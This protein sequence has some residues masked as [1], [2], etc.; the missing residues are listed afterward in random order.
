MDKIT[1]NSYIKNFTLLLLFLLSTIAIQG[2]E[3]C[4]NNIDDDGD[5]LI[6]GCDSEC[7][8]LIF[9]ES[10]ENATNAG[11]IGPNCLGFEIG[12]HETWLIGTVAPFA[13]DNTQGISGNWSTSGRIWYTNN[14]NPCS[15]SGGVPTAVNFPDGNVALY[16][17]ETPAGS[18]VEFTFPS[19][20]FNVSNKYFFSIDVWNDAELGDTG[21]QVDITSTV[22]GLLQST[23]LQ[24]DAVT[25]SDGNF[26][27]LQTEIC[28]DAGAI[29]IRLTELTVMGA[30]ASPVIDNLRIT[31]SSCVFDPGSNGT[32]CFETTDTPADL[33]NFLAGSPDTGGSWSPTLAS[34]TGVFDPSV[35]TAGTY[36]YSGSLCGGGTADV[37]VTIG[38]CL[39]PPIDSD[40]DTISDFI[41]LDDDN[42]GILDKIE[43]DCFSNP[44]TAQLARWDPNIGLTN[45]SNNGNTGA[46]K[47]DRYQPSF[48]NDTYL[49]LTVSNL[50]F[51]TGVTD[52]SLDTSILTGNDVA[53]HG[54]VWVSGIDGA[55]VADA[56]TNNDYIDFSFKIK[57][58]VDI[59]ARFDNI[60]DVTT[61]ITGIWG[62]RGTNISTD[63]RKPIY[64]D[65]SYQVEISSDGFAT[66]SQILSAAHPTTR[67]TSG[68]TFTTSQGD[69]QFN[70]FDNFQ[71]GAGPSNDVLLQA[72]TTYT[73][74]IYLFAAEDVGNNVTLDNFNISINPCTEYDTDND[75]IANIYDLDSDNDGCADLEEAAG[76]FTV[77]DNGVTATG[78]LTD[79]NGGVVT[80]NLGNTV[81]ATLA[82]V[83][84]AAGGGQG[85]G[86][87]QDGINYCEDFDDD[88]V[89]DEVDLDDDN[90]GILDEFDVC[91]I[92]TTTTDP[93]GAA[94]N[95]EAAGF[96]I[97]SVGG[98]TDI[99]GALDNGFEQAVIR[100]G[101]N[102]STLS[103]ASDYITT[104][105][106]GGGTADTSVIQFSNGTITYLDTYAADAEAELRTTTAGGFI[107]GDTGSGVYVESEF[108]GDVD[109]EYTVSYNFTTPVTLFSV[110]M[111]D[112]FDTFANPP[113][114]SGVILQYEILADGQL[115]AYLRDEPT[116]DDT[117]GS[118]D[119]YDGVGTLRGTV[120]SGQNIETTI[121]FIT[122]DPV[123][124][125]AIRHRIVQGFLGPFIVGPTNFNAVRD[126][127]GL[128]QFSFSTDTL[129]GNS[130]DVDSDNDGCPDAVEASGSFVVAD[131]TSSNNLADADE[132][133]VDATGVP[134]DGP[135]GSQ[136]TQNATADYLDAGVENCTDS[137]L[138]GIPDSVDLD[139]DND[140]IL[141][142]EEQIEC[143][144]SGIISVSSATSTSPITDIGL[145]VDGILDQTRMTFSSLSSYTTDITVEFA[146]SQ[147]GDIKFE[148]YNDGGTQNNGG[149]TA[150]GIGEF[151]S[152]EVYDSS[153][154]LI[155]SQA[156]F[157]IP[158]FATGDTSVLDSTQDIHLIFEE[159]LIDATTIIVKG[160]VG[161]NGDSDP[162]VSSTFAIEEVREFLFTKTC[163]ATLTHFDQDTDGDGVSDRLDLDSDGDG[164]PDAV[165]GSD[166]FVIGNLSDANGIGDLDGG[167]TGGTFTGT[168]SPVTTNL[169]GDYGSV[170]DP[171][172]SNYVDSQGRVTI[173]TVSNTSPG[174][175][176]TITQTEGV[177]QDG[178]IDACL[179][180]DM[181]TIPDYVDIDD[182]NDGI[183]DVDELGCGLSTS[184]ITTANTVLTA[185]SG[186]FEGTFANDT[187]AADYD[188]DFTNVNTNFQTAN[189]TAT[190]SGVHYIVD[191]STPGGAYEATFMITPQ[192]GTV[193]GFV[194]W[195]PNL[196]GNAD[197]ENDNDEQ[198]ITLTWSPN[199][200]AKIIDPDD[201]LD[202]GA[203]T[204]VNNLVITSGTT[205]TQGAEFE[206][207]NPPTWRIRFET[208][209]Y[210][211]AF[212]F[213]TAHVGFTGVS[214]LTDEGFSL[215]T[216][217]CTLLDSGGTAEPNHRDTDSDGDSCNDS[218]EAGTHPDNS[219][220][221]LTTVAT[222]VGANGLLNSL[223]TTLD[224]GIINYDG[225]FIGDSQTTVFNK[226]TDETGSC[227][228]GFDNDRDGYTDNFDADCNPLGIPGCIGDANA[229]DFSIQEDICTT[230]GG[231]TAYQ[232]PMVADI[233]QDGSPEI[234]VGSTTGGSNI[235]MLN[236]IDM[237]IDYT[238]PVDEGTILAK[239]NAVGVAQLDGAGFLDVAYITS[240]DKLLVARYNGATWDNFES[241]TI[242]TTVMNSTADGQTN[243]TISF[244]DF[245][246]DGTPEVYVGNQI[247]SIDFGCTTQP[248]I[249]VINGQNFG[250]TNGDNGPNSGAFSVAYDILNRTQCN[251]DP[252]CDGLELIAGYQVYS[253]NM[254]TGIMKVQKDL[255]VIQTD[256][257]FN[258]GP[259]G[260]ADM[261]LDG[262]VDVVVNSGSR[263]Y[264]WDPANEQLVRS[265]AR[266]GTSVALP[267]IGNFYDDDLADDSMLNNSIP[268]VPEVTV[269]VG[270]TLTTYNINNASAIWTL[271]TTDSSAATSLTAFDF[272]GDGFDE[273][274][275]RDTTTLRVM[276]GG[277]AA[278]TPAGVDANRN[279]QTFACSSATGWEHPVVA[280]VDEDG[281]AEIVVACNPQICIYETAS[282]PWQPAREIWNQFSYNVVNINEDGTVPSQQQ[283]ILAIFP[284]GGPGEMIFNGFGN[285]LNPVRTVL[286]K[287]DVAVPDGILTITN[288]TVDCPNV[289]I[290]F[291]IENQGDAPFPLNSSITVYDGD[292]TATATTAV[293][294]HTFTT[295][296][297]VAVSST[298]NFSET[299]SVPTTIANP[300]D[301]Y[302]VINDDGTTTLPF[303]TTDANFPASSTSECDY[304]NNI[305]NT[306]GNMCADFD[307]DTIPDF[308][309]VDD[310]NDGILDTDECP[311]TFTVAEVTAAASQGGYIYDEY[312]A[313]GSFR[314][315]INYSFTNPHT[316]M[317]GFVTQPKA[318]FGEVLEPLNLQDGSAFDS[319]NLNENEAIT[320]VGTSFA[321]RDPGGTSSSSAT[322]WQ[323]ARGYLYIP[324]NISSDFTIQLTETSVSTSHLYLATTDSGIYDATNSTFNSGVINE[325]TTDFS[326][327]KL[328]NDVGIGA[329]GAVGDGVTGQ[330]NGAAAGNNEIISISQTQAG[331]FVAFVML[332]TD[333]G[334][335]GRV[336]MTTGASTFIFGALPT[337]FANTLAC[338]TDMDGIINSLDLDSDGD[339]CPD[340][341]EAGVSPTTGIGQ[342]TIENGSG[343]SVTTTTP[344]VDNAVFT[345]VSDMTNDS[346]GDGLLDSIDDNGGSGTLDGT[347]EYTSSYTSFALDENVDACLDSDGDLIADVFDVDDDNDGILDVDEGCTSPDTYDLGVFQSDFNTTVGGTLNPYT[348][349][350]ID[351][352]GL[353]ITYSVSG[354]VSDVL[355][356]GSGT[357]TSGISPGIITNSVGN[358][359]HINANDAGNDDPLIVNLDFSKPIAG[360]TFGFYD[361]DGDGVGFDDLTVV[362]GYDV[363]DNVILPSVITPGSVSEVYD[364]SNEMF[365]YPS[366]GVSP[367]LGLRGTASSNSQINPSSVTF[368][369]FK[370]IKRIEIYYGNSDAILN[371]MQHRFYLDLTTFSSCTQGLDLDKDGIINSLDLDSDGDGCPDA[372]EGD[373]S[374]EQTDLSDASTTLLNQPNNNNN[375]GSIATGY[376][377]NTTESV[378]ANL[379][380]SNGVDTDPMSATYGVPLTTLANTPNTQ[381][382]G[383]SQDVNDDT[384]CCDIVPPTI[385]PN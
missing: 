278:F 301:L 305:A 247:Y 18:Y 157:L 40:G 148:L 296:T 39:P 216:G 15:S 32:T 24:Y 93:I 265:F 178:A 198:D 184:T 354:D 207:I 364:A 65:W 282:D 374:F 368:S 149:S 245:N 139:D 194:E 10:F 94:V 146:S 277:P 355:L 173:A 223:E 162:S 244:A 339:G 205:I 233:D 193:L 250:V 279:Y 379:T 357:G 328:V 276:Y 130:K 334:V 385:A 160:I 246:Q 312:N 240:T 380:N 126:P 367:T 102:I 97:F 321:F 190:A 85:V 164:C 89:P 72:G 297:A 340:A 350:N 196:V 300:F 325:V 252:D 120:G 7:G 90:D 270:S 235:R 197:A 311:V 360:A 210:D 202:V 266:S 191:D 12:D 356:G 27:L 203:T 310:D 133:D 238:F 295:T 99:T 155:Y 211:A 344:N 371:P 171:V 137:D 251:G 143:T 268:D 254:T 3:V 358:A 309:D 232:T 236:P 112:I 280:D 41:D 106:V 67:N 87:T 8:T 324:D 176:A 227:D 33:F 19:G 377:G 225:A 298:E 343:G 11:L 215:I 116:G 219:L 272:N 258:D 66:N 382:I 323:I 287:N 342:G 303:D 284:E 290:E 170:A 158:G 363:D 314:D 68:A 111:V 224:S 113:N 168:G 177:S 261:D 134:L 221:V 253:V 30:T 145:L 165:E 16:L 161:Y 248:C 31:E 271:A 262:D 28:G 98:N 348:F 188:V 376:L 375:D 60:I 70:E 20:T 229:P 209:I 239:W 88:G 264:I 151:D 260:I 122:E 127:H 38:G 25:A 147:T 263:L 353:D 76:N 36:T 241:T 47:T 208:N 132:G 49:D 349:I 330:G 361:V 206:N 326:N 318:G 9:Q 186:H 313:N 100:E 84:N 370:E 159:Q 63:P 347:P 77:A 6:D 306:T 125:V 53:S 242:P 331:K 115:I 365:N 59:V 256:N 50:G 259:T 22:G 352:Q 175:D 52:E 292:P 54:Y 316:G 255:R 200:V 69:A 299:F 107:S 315:Q 45:E 101:V 144:A 135:G 154:A 286:A 302:M 141:D 293:A 195:G 378:I 4:N 82:G 351:G 5:G 51:G 307:G 308:V 179:D 109:D 42:D 96:R 169:T 217:V 218:F 319:V 78:T 61:D 234:I 320:T 214:N 275:Y 156:G 267:V 249:S 317:V 23:Q 128:D 167:N 62:P 369:N 44:L 166:S 140:G 91:D 274:V 43:A 289:T 285:Q 333:N 17:N 257:G 150:S 123:S 117:V 237:S 108:N 2:Q 273:L 337:S 183:L 181:D 338:D 64:A 119:I 172:A 114:P 29:T 362:I 381:G 199:F 124:I 34:G 189:L 213:T 329:S 1:F 226:C 103:S 14:T 204:A 21:L 201:Q 152:V 335:Q 346:N 304:T 366:D 332:T 58:D 131:L 79:G 291:S 327:L 48:V 35:D 80:T 81:G 384:S 231:Y 336:T 288:T 192:A 138:D 83:P 220:P 104:G 110:D 92:T 228:D 222:A 136:T 86:N 37:V 182:D 383:G 46:A 283:N 105:S 121:S 73:I 373:L 142:T 185:A 74:R 95:W 243:G 187:A 212:T 129:C 13:T 153:G 341:V 75:G 372:I 180:F 281:Q 269:L 294:L 71:D 230:T 118:V 174:T 359:I 322:A 163:S 56:R 26:D 345:F 55:S 57:D